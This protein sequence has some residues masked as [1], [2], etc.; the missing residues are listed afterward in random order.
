MRAFM[1]EVSFE[2][3]GTVVHMHKK[4]NGGSATSEKVQ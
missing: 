4:P 3:G 1:D 2:E